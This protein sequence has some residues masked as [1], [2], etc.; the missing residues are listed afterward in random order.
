MESRRGRRRKIEAEDLSLFGE[1]LEDIFK[2]GDIIQTQIAAACGIADS[3]LSQM[4]V[5]VRLTRNNV[6]RLIEG[7]V[8]T[9]FLTP[10]NFEQIA[11]NLLELADEK[12]LN[13]YHKRDSE[14]YRLIRKPQQNNVKNRTP[15]RSSFFNNNH[16]VIAIP[17]I[18]CV[19]VCEGNSNYK[20]K[21]LLLKK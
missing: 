14:V 6:R 3:T 18:E 20:V 8:K 16:V 17:A 19:I 2:R 4:K 10:D 5:G 13:K 7:L 1:A 21:K 11:N 9:E 12:P 15:D